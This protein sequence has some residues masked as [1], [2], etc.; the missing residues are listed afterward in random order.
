VEKV[1]AVSEAQTL[2]HLLHYGRIEGVGEFNLKVGFLFY[3]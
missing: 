2:Q 1:L 3:F